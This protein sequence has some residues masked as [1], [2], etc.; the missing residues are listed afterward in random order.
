MK[1][2]VPSVDFHYCRH[3]YILVYSEIIPHLTGARVIS[4]KHPGVSTVFIAIQ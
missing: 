4:E 3:L 2:E 1:T